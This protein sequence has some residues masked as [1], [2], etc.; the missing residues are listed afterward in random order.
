MYRIRKAT[1]EDAS[2]I[3]EILIFAKRMSYRSIFRN[4]KVSFGEMQVYPQAKEYIE[5]P[6]KIQN[7]WVYDDEFV[8]GMI[9]IERNRIKEL[10]VDTFFQNQGIGRKLVEFAVAQKNCNYLWVLEKNIKAIEFY[11]AQGFMITTE[12][13]LEEGTTAYIIKM[14][15]YCDRKE[16]G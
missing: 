7:I 16:L 15:R 4:D 1:C 2:R 12:K 14:E 3:A 11:K 5:C 13:Q 10:Y 9:N 8:K 6:D